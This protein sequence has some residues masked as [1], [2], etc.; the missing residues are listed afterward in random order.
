MTTSGG[1]RPSLTNPLA[2]FPD[3]L[4]VQMWSSTTSPS[5]LHGSLAADSPAIVDIQPRAELSPSLRYAARRELPGL[6]IGRRCMA[7][8]R[9][10]ALRSWLA[11]NDVVG[12]R[13]APIRLA[14]VQRRDRSA[15][16]ASFTLLGVKLGAIGFCP[17]S[18][19]EHKRRCG[20]GA[21]G[22]RLRLAH[23]KAP[24]RC[25]DGACL[26]S[27]VLML[28]VPLAQSLQ[29]FS[30]DF[31]VGPCARGRTTVLDETTIA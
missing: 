31:H 13:S 3:P 23:E 27:V 17:T 28:A 22:L 18:E 11:A 29:S 5:C 7:D 19:A 20:E 6:T 2:T 9:G 1:A 21:M 25:T 8:R 16:R 14:V 26:M 4:R 12:H 10:A 30:D 24:C 15:P